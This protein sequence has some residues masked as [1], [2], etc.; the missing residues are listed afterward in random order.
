ME[1]MHGFFS[2]MLNTLFA[3]ATNR[4]QHIALC[5]R[6]INRVKSGGNNDNILKAGNSNR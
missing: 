4:L 3:M 1:H 2:S 5:D 6:I